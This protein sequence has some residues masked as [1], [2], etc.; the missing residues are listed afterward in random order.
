MEIDRACLY[1]L[2]YLVLDEQGDTD[3]KREESKLEP[4]GSRVLK[5]DFQ[6]PSRDCFEWTATCNDQATNSPL[7]MLRN[8][9][10]RKLDQFPQELS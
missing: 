4:R 5:M 9:V 10:F 7:C 6:T 1:S 8:Q 3:A 2:P